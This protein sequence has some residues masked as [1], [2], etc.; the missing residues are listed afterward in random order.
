MISIIIFWCNCICREVFLDFDPASVAKLNEKKII[1][2]GS[3]ASSLLSEPKL[4]AVVENARQILKVY[5]H[6]YHY[7]LKEK[8][9]TDTILAKVSCCYIGYEEQEADGTWLRHVWHFL[10]PKKKK[11]NIFLEKG[12]CHW[13]DAFLGNY[14]SNHW[15]FLACFASFSMGKEVG[16]PF[17]IPF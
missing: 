10:V 9:P 13:C 17:F 6:H 14:F 12:F 11:G 3:T 4:R 7:L 15:V 8:A 1:A 2:T 5:H 16:N